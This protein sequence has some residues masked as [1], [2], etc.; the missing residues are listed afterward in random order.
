MVLIYLVGWKLSN[1][2]PSVRR[3]ASV[4]QLPRQALRQSNFFII[5]INC[6]FLPDRE[7]AFWVRMTKV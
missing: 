2:H 7:D 5:K 6:H 1:Y 3:M 4:G